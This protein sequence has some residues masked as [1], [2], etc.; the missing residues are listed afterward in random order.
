VIPGIPRFGVFLGACRQGGGGP[1]N[2]RKREEK[3]GKG[4][5]REEKGGKE[6][7]GKKKKSRLVNC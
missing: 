1:G 3:G 6:G 7:K 5:K 4:R 2:E